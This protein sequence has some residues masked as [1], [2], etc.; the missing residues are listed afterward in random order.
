MDGLVPNLNT[1]QIKS[2]IRSEVLVVI[3]GHIDDAGA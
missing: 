2:G 1:G 3:A